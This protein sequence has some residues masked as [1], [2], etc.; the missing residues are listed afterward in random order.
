MKNLLPIIFILCYSVSGYGQLDSVSQAAEST[1]IQ[2]PAQPVVKPAPVKKNLFDSTRP[3]RRVPDSLARARRQLR[4]RLLRDSLLTDSLRLAD[5][6][7]KA[8]G[9]ARLS[10]PVA[11]RDTSTYR[12]YETHPFLP[13]DKRAVYM[14]IDYHKRESKDQLFYLMAG[15]VFCVAFIRAGFSKYFRNLFLLF[16]QTSIRQKQNREQFLQ[17]NFASLLTNLL[18]FISTGLYITLLIKY[19]HWVPGSFGLVALVCA[20]ALVVIYVGKY[21]FLL[22]AGWVF[23]TREA[24]GSYIFVVFM[25]N[26][27]MG[28]ALIPFL[29]LLSFGS[30]EVANA[31]VTVS[32][33]L[34]ALLFVYRYFVS[35]GALRNKLKV[36]ALHFLLYLCAVELLPLLLI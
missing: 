35:F 29:L 13:L 25:V 2:P 17:D 12:R 14:L 24:A 22:F 21:L 30:P 19:K 18:F 1:R 23:N 36:N 16:F 20:A 34:I 31:T 9:P 6:S 5:S 3:I 32:I 26:K 10:R 33:G 27:V 7:L 11:H 15:I 28:V 4:A 8:A